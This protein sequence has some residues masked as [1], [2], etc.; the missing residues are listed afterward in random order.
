MI[1]KI[2]QKPVVNVKKIEACALMAFSGGTNTGMNV[3]N[4]RIAS[5]NYTVL[6]KQSSVW[7][8]PSAESETGW[9]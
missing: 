3:D 7:D 4:T 1:K 6:G 5:P 9:D 8:D 2:Y